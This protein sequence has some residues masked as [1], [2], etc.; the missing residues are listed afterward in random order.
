M[1]GIGRE[2]QSRRYCTRC[3]AQVSVEDAFCGSCGARL[4]SSG[5]GNPSG[6][7]QADGTLQVL[8]DRVRTVASGKDALLG[9]SLGTGV[10]AAILGLILA[11]L[12][13]Y[14]VF[15]GQEIS[16]SLGPVLYALIHGGAASL[17]VP[18]IP[19]FF[20]IGGS[21]RLGLPISSFALLPFL[22]LLVGSRFLVSRARS[23]IPFA[24]ATIL[25]YSLLVGVIAALGSTLVE[26]GEGTSVSLSAAPFSAALWSLLWALLGTTLGV[27]ASRGPLLPAH[28]RQV[29]W[30]G[31][32][33]VGVSTVLALVLTLILAL[34]QQATGAQGPGVPAQQIPGDLGQPVAPG[35]AGVEGALAGIGGLFTLLPMALGMLW[36]LANGV[37]VGLQNVPDLSQI[38]L[39]GPELADAT[40][41]ASLVGAWPLWAG[42][43]LLL[44]APVIGLL[45]GGMVAS[46]GASSNERWWRGALV[47]IPYT[48]IALLVALMVGITAN[49]TI[50]GGE[51]DVAFGAS[52]P[53]LVLL[54]PAG[55]ILGAL[56]SFLAREG[57]SGVPRP[58]RTFLAAAAASSVLLLG[59]LPIL[60]APFASSGPGF[61]NLE[62]G[63][64]PT[65]DQPLTTQEPEPT[66]EDPESSPE[67]V[68]SEISP[69]TAP[70]P[71]FDELLP[72]L[73]ATTTAPIM[74]PAELP[75]ELQNVAVD[76]DL[77][78]EE[79]GILFL[80]EPTGE[81]VETFVHANSVGTFTASPQPNNANSEFFEA[82]ST[83]TVELPD[84]TEATLRY[85]EPTM[86][87]GNQGPFWEG[88]FERDGYH[89]NLMVPINDPSGE[90]AERVLS[91]MVEVEDV[92]GEMAP[93]D[94]L[95]LQ[96]QYINADDYEAAYDLFAEESKQLVSPEQYRAYFENAGFYDIVDY[97]FVSVQVE[98]DTATVVTD[99]VVSSGIAGEEHYQRTQ[100][101]VREDGA[102]RVVMRDEQIEVFTGS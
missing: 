47:A 64:L 20:G 27:T 54:L 62:E 50:M 1:S 34:I 3:G 23:S 21:L 77:S 89:Y 90:V 73:Q 99:Y 52:L 22:V 88:R 82:T 14:N 15:G 75:E 97:T 65:P 87:G 13:L 91:S 26:G 42:W 68:S 33:A 2:K 48:A 101:L 7:A 96:Y 85:M 44:L 60:A 100:Q 49:I 70:A 24:A 25:S 35:E 59:S 80:G 66:E 69:D 83:R 95:A 53:W 4:S 55:A 94:V 8:A 78:G 102:W 67:E 36:L 79:Y 56:G 6:L 58:R 39:V 98:G 5:E 19:A 28:M 40:L 76:A 16:Y 84:G 10:A 45:V 72:V 93:E 61:A 31:L 18:P 29:A 32:W 81:V 11:L 57:A 92:Y 37:P 12:L 51:V 46:R 43:R 41:R 86:E 30:G 38:P 17:D 71:A 9:L 63:P 74:L